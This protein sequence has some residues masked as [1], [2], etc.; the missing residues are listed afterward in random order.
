MFKQIQDYRMAL[1][2]ETIPTIEPIHFWKARETRREATESSQY[3]PISSWLL[4]IVTEYR[5]DLDLLVRIKL[6]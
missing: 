4:N 6:S 1:Q 5:R 3:L 2:A